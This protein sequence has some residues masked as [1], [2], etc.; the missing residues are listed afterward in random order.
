MYPELTT[1]LPSDRERTIRREY[2]IRLATIAILGAA[3]LTLA[4]AALLAPSYAFLLTQE[5]NKTDR[6]AL[7]EST[8]VSA[9]EAALSARLAALSADA[10]QLT[11]LGEHE[12]VMSRIQAV[13]SVD[14][15][16]VAVTNIAYSPTS[17]KA[18]TIAIS[19]TAT[20]R[21][22]LRAYQL[23]LAGAAFSAG[24]DLPVSA[25]AKDADIPFTITVT[26]AQ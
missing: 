21:N 11:K 15:S 10:N 9:D 13:L 19:G 25:Y 8:L 20:T 1:L 14:H 23:A 7:L 17:G 12:S 5:K 26:L 6:L 18:G 4:A 16:G 22:A 24:A 3:A 2:F